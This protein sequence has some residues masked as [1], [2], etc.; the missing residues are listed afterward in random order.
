LLPGRE[1]EVGKWWGR[2]SMVQILYT[3]IYKW[4]ND[5]CW[6]YSRNGGKGKWRRLV[7]GVYS[8]MIYLIYYKKFC[9]CHH[10]PYPEQK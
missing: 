10:V 6:N 4:K 3:C 2:V 8:S 7:E 9:K 5:I 1:E